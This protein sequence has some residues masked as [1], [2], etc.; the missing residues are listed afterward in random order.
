MVRDVT[1]GSVLSRNLIPADDKLVC[2]TS[3]VIVASQFISGYR[4]CNEIGMVRIHGVYDAILHA[5]IRGGFKD[6]AM[7]DEYVERN[8]WHKTS[9]DMLDEAVERAGGADAVLD[10]LDMVNFNHANQVTQ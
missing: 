1:S 4:Q 7:L 8:I 10:M 2:A 5:A 6:G 3:I 9:L